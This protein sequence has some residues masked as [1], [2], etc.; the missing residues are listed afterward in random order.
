MKREGDPAD[1]RL[2]VIFL[3]SLPGWTQKELAERAG[4][5]KGAI[6]DYELGKTAPSEKTLRRIVEAVGVS[7]VK[8]RR[9]LPVFRTVR[10]GLEEGKPRDRAGAGDPAGA[11]VSRLSRSA[12]DA[13]EAGVTPALLEIPWLSGL[14]RPPSSAEE[15]RKAA[16]LWETVKGLDSEDR[17]KVVTVAP[18]YHTW[19]FCERLR[20]ESARIAVDD[21]G[22]ALELAGLARRVAESRS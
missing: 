5:D 3:R 20:E 1:L 11:L 12:G 14:E 8:A 17:E 13:V 4:V 9:L 2:L 18:G 16:A 6:S 15:R 7:Y 19:A 22:R 21:A 10:L